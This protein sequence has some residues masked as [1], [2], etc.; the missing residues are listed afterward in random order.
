MQNVA[1]LDTRRNIIPHFIQCTLTFEAKYGIIPHLIMNRFK[2]SDFLNR[3]S[4]DNKCLLQIK[5]LLY[6]DGITCELCEKVTPHYKIRGR[7]AFACQFCGNHVH[8]LAGTIFEKSKTPL[9]YWFHAMFLMI[10]TRA[11]ISAKQLERELGVTYK[12]AWR[13]NHQIR[14]LMAE[15]NLVPLDGDVEV[16]EAYIGGKFQNRIRGHSQGVQ[17][18]QVL[19]GMVKRGGK[20][21][22]RH[23]PSSDRFSLVS[24]INLLVDPKARIISDEHPAYWQLVRE[25]YKHDSINHGKGEFGRGDVHTNT[26]ENVWSHLKR[27]IYGVYRQVSK[28]HL[29]A[30]ADEYAFRYNHRNSSGVMFFSLLEQVSYVRAVSSERLLEDQ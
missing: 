28:K 8:I 15:T 20:V 30:Y 10:N 21:Y 19:M 16:D 23:V 6:P 9:S 26:I 7:K 14:K 29:Q 11:G 27:G 5:E 18:K 17:H 2:L 22:I 13:M 12:T 1:G 3:F 4:D 24:Q 25:G